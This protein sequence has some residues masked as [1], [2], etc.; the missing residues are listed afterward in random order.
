M[1]KFVILWELPKCNPETWSEHKL[2]GKWSWAQGHHGTG[3]RS[4]GRAGAPACHLQLQWLPERWPGLLMHLAHS[5]AWWSSFLQWGSNILKDWGNAKARQ[6][7]KSRV[8]II[9]KAMFSLP[10]GKN[11]NRELG[12]GQKDEVLISEPNS[13]ISRSSGFSSEART[14]IYLSSTLWKPHRNL[15]LCG[16]CDHCAVG[17]PPWSLRRLSRSMLWQLKW[18]SHTSHSND[19]GHP[20]ICFTSYEHLNFY[21]REIHALFCLLCSFS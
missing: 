21:S 3:Q 5:A 17:R 18:T 2:A 10:W 12:H 14:N 8:T 4:T 6:G 1:K 13:L 7:W 9:Y 19:C 20:L 16:W 11:P 15:G